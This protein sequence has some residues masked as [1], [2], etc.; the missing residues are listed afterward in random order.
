MDA[1]DYAVPIYVKLRGG[2]GGVKQHQGHLATHRYCIQHEYY[3][4]G[5]KQGSSG[6]TLSIHASASPNVRK[7]SQGFE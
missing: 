6:F 1:V 4:S 5:S 2:G 7:T 3:T